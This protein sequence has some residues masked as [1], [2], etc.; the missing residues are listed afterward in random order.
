MDEN[1]DQS[2]SAVECTAAPAPRLTKIPE[3]EKILACFFF[4]IAVSIRIG[5]ENLCLPYAGFFY[6][7]LGTPPLWAGIFF[8]Y[9]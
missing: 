6:Q 5:Q 1:V 4:C 8:V 3:E 7:L 9:S 2:C